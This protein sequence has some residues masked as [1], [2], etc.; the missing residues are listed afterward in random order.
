[1]ESKRG[2]YIVNNLFDFDYYKAK[3]KE[4]YE[5][6]SG[7]DPILQEKTKKRFNHS[8]G[9]CDMTE[10]LIKIHN[11]PID[12]NKAKIA[13]I[14]HDYAKYSPKEEFETVAKIY[15]KEEI[16]KDEYK[17]VWHALLG[18]YIVEDELGIDDEEILS[19]IET[20]STGNKDKTHH[21][22]RYGGWS[23][24]MVQWE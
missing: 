20:H 9:V 3:L 15:H 13:A 4:K 16:L 23:C 2:N 24:G 11:L 7:E 21:L 17:K 22:W 8:L 12:L 19:A 6:C 18:R 5:L 14:L 1:M 10:E